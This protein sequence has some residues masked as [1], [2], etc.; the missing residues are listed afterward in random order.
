MK[1]L[2][3]NIKNASSNNLINHQITSKLDWFKEDYFSRFLQSAGINS[4][5][6]CMTQSSPNK[7]QFNTVRKFLSSFFFPTKYQNIKGH[8]STPSGSFFFF[9]FIPVIT[10]RDAIQVQHSPEVSFLFFLTN[11]KT[12][13]VFLQTAY[14]TASS[15]CN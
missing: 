1:I 6:W 15:Y 5:F 4:K 10:K 2:S 11:T 3:N 7:S 13:R 9:F 8:N 14:R 12:S